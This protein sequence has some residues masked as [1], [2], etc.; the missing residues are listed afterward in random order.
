MAVLNALDNSMEYKKST[1]AGWTAV[2]TSSMVL[3]P[4]NSTIGYLFRYKSF[5]QTFPS[6]QRS[7]NLNGRG[8]APSCTYNASTETISSLNST[9]E[10]KFNDGGY[11]TIV[12]GITGTTMNLSSLIDDL[13]SDDTL[14]VS[15]RFKATSTF[16]ASNVKQ[17]TIYPRDSGHSAMALNFAEE[18][19]EVEINHDGHFIAKSD[20]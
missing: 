19:A 12:S 18:E 15:V 6:A 8:N 1:D 14:V 7:L 3:E 17:F 9:M 10:I 16:P 4:Q 2:T 5:G 20:C 13:S 11:S